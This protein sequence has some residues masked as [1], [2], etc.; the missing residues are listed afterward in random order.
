MVGSNDSIPIQQQFS[1]SF[2]KVN[3]NRKSPNQTIRLSPSSSSSSSCSQQQQQQQQ[4]RSKSL[5][6][7]QILTSDQFRR[8]STPIMSTTPRLSIADRFMSSNYQHS[9]LTSSPLSYTSTILNDKEDLFSSD[10]NPSNSDRTNNNNNNNIQASSSSM[11]ISST[12][13]LTIASAFMKSSSTFTK[14]DHTTVASTGTIHPLDTLSQ[15]TNDSLDLN[16]DLTPTPSS[17]N[18]YRGSRNH[19]RPFGSQDTLVSN[20]LGTNKQAKVQ[21]STE[22]EYFDISLNDYYRR[23]QDNDQQEDGDEDDDGT[24]ENESDISSTT[25]HGD[26]EHDLDLQQSKS[27][28]KHNQQQD[29]MMEPRGCWIGCCFLSFGRRPNKQAMMAN[30][31]KKRQQEQQERQQQRKCGTRWRVLG[32]FLSIL[33]LI[34][35]SSILWPR[36]PLIR[37]EGASLISPAKI[38][39][40]NQGALVG[41]VQFESQWMVN[42]TVDN[43]QNSIL[44]TRLVQLHVLVK[45]ALTGNIIGK[46]FQNDHP[47]PLVLSPNTISTIQLGVSLDYQARDVS[48]TT[49][50][51]LKKACTSSSPTRR[52]LLISRGGDHPS[53]LSSS[54]SDGSSNTT[55]I[56]SNNHTLSNNNNQ[57]TIHSPTTIPPSPPPP[58]KQHESLSLLFWVTLHI[59][60]LDFFGYQPT[61]MVAP[62]TGGFVCP[63]S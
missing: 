32:I 51:S 1:S 34:V 49:F 33:L 17:S 7:Q 43:R 14:Q 13:R 38:T 23:S 44:P 58:P 15:H 56:N 10:K 53:N 24:N 62:A 6:S 4:R 61:V 5:T 63:L 18:F 48:D 30:I 52:S 25:R 19:S 12:P 42:F 35:L 16:L 28:S 50:A 40:T 20:D 29:D 57:T 46:G 41:N 2:P 27:S 37:I 45:D 47:E 36:T 11:E 9:P 26:E 54:N 22:D 59:W 3:D 39:E 60:G 31:N 55:V 21:N 8:P